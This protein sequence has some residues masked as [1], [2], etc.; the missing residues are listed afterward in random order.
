MTVSSNEIPSLSAKVKFLS[1]G[2]S[3]VESFI[4]LIRKEAPLKT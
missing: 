3:L 2:K 1:W 4:I